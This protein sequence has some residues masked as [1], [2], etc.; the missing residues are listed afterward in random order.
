MSG[1]RHAVIACLISFSVVAQR[2]DSLD[3]ELKIAESELAQLQVATFH[4][5]KEA[6]R[7]DGN[8]RFLGAWDRI[9]SN[10]RVLSYPFASLK[11]VSVLNSKDGKLRLVTWNLF[12]DDGTHIYFG[13]LFVNNEK[14]VKK[15]FLRSEKTSEFN[16]FKLLDRSMTIK[17]P[18]TFTGSPDKWFG[19]LYTQLIDCGDYYTLIGWDGN[20]KLTQRKFIDVL[21]F[22]N[23]GAPV[24]GKDVF[25]FPRRNPRRLMFEYSNEVSMSLKY[26]EKKGQIIYSH[27]ASKQEGEL[28]EGQYQFYGPDGSFDALQLHK[29]RWVLVEDV[30]ARN[31]KSPND[32]AQ[33][34]DPRKQKPLYTPK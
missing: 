25:K 22:K 28:L 24:F 17:N 8:K 1:L 26:H 34:P 14:H 33:K 27:L 2:A 30:D 10:P 20:D 7:I 5:K 19:M 23:D 15:G 13:Y 31:E 12:K 21:Y 32:N 18:E 4:S 6:E 16:A 11:D 9:A 29:D 3:Y